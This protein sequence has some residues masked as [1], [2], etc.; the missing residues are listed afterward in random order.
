MPRIRS[1]KPEFWQDSRMANQPALVRTTFL[2]LWSMADDEGR[3]EG[4]AIA[5]WRFGSFR[6]DSR[7]VAKALGT[8]ASIGRILIYE[9][10]GNPY[11]QVVHFNRHQRID[12]PTKSKYPEY[13]NGHDLF[14]DGSKNPREDSRKLAPDLDLDLGAGIKEQ[15]SRSREQGRDHNPRAR[16]LRAGV[17]C[18]SGS[19]KKPGMAGLKCA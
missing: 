8:L 6:E 2:C 12:H 14:S 11:M 9:V 13:S 16:R 7:E 18:P 5:V 1:I 10:E 17:G 15:G 3:L 4:D 19:R